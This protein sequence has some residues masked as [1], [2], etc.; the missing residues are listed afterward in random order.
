MIQLL[1]SKLLWLD[2]IGIFLD[3][4]ALIIGYNGNG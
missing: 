1:K 3:K 4:T 2:S